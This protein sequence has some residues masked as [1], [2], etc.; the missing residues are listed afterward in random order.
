MIVV[1]AGKENHDQ[2]TDCGILVRYFSEQVG[3]L[4]VVMTIFSLDIFFLKNPRAE[5]IGD[6]FCGTPVNILSSTFKDNSHKAP[7]VASL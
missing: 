6:T 5:L 3:V 4:T 7:V 2:S 1:D